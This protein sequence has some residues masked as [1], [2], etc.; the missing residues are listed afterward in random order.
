MSLAKF[1][2]QTRCHPS[3]PLFA[4]AKTRSYRFDAS[5]LG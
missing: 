3:L 1:A 4:A 5:S 2:G